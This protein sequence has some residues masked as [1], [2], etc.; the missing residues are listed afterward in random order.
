MSPIHCSLGPDV[1]IEAEDFRAAKEPRGHYHCR[2]DQQCEPEPH[3]R[4]ALLWTTTRFAEHQSQPGTS[5][6][7]GSQPAVCNQDPGSI[8]PAKTCHEPAKEDGDHGGCCSSP[9]AKAGNDIK[10]RLAC[11]PLQQLRRRCRRQQP[12]GEMHGCGV[13]FSKPKDEFCQEFPGRFAFLRF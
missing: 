5:H 12:D 6:S 7:G 13:E 8:G 4:S 1:M 10:S 2:Y 11:G 3:S 9:Q